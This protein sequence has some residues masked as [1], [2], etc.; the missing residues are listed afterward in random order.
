MEIKPLLLDTNAYAA[1]KIIA[2]NEFTAEHYANIYR[3]PRE[4]GKPIPTND[5]WIA[6]TAQQYS[7]ALFT[8]D[9]YFQVI[10]N[11]PTGAT[12]SDFSS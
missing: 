1:Y 8:Y 2:I 3:S 10:E 6:A 5:M 11:L 7:L 4:R 12:L 9:R